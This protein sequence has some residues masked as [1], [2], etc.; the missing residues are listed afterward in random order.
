MIY[1]RKTCAG[2]NVWNIILDFAG[3]V[4]SFVQLLGDAID[5]DD[6]SS[7]T[8]NAAKLGLSII[9]IGF[10]VSTH[11]KTFRVNF[12]FDISNN[13]F[14]RVDNFLPSALRLVSRRS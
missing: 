6:F 3:A 11:Y 1:S 2:W 14:G 5:L 7:I 4:L 9:S 12:I 8:G 10:D 13:L